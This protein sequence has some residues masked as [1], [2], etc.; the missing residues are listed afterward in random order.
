[1]A[2]KLS[3]RDSCEDPDE[4]M[5]PFRDSPGEKEPEVVSSLIRELISRRLLPRVKKIRTSLRR[6]R[7]G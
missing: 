6:N 1:M 3:W 5:A 4:W 2:R 7:D